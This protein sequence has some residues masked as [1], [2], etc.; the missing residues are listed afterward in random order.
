M[1]SFQGYSATKEQVG[2]LFTILSIMR[3]HGS[4]MEQR[5]IDQ[6]LGPFKPDVD[7][8]GNVTVRI[9]KAPVLWSCHVDTVH[10]FG[11]IAPLKLH[12]D[13]LI[14]LHPKARANCLGA[15]DGAGVWL[16]LQMIRAKR[17]GLYVF[18]RG[19][20]R[21]GIGSKWL[22][23]NKPDML[24][25]YS[26]A[27]AFD[28]KDI[29]SI[30][31]HQW[32]GRCCSEDFSQSLSKAIGLDM[33][34]DS[35]GSF[36][37]TASYTD[38][39]GECTNVSVGYKGQHGRAEEQNLPFLLSLLDRML[40]LDV[41]DLVYKR[42]PGEKEAKKSWA[43][44][45]AGSGDADSHYYHGGYHGG[46]RHRSP[47]PS[48]SLYGERYK[49]EKDKIWS[50]QEQGYVYP[51]SSGKMWDAKLQK[52]VFDPNM[53]WDA[54]AG[55]FK[56]K[57]A[58]AKGV[59]SYMDTNSRWKVGRKLDDETVVPETYLALVQDFPEQI[60]GILADK[61]YGMGYLHDQ[62]RKNGGKVRTQYLA[63]EEK[64]TASGIICG[65]CQRLLKFCACK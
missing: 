50:V 29:G 54:T 44:P 16:M 26:A 40:E 46:S 45:G 55:Y 63:K 14:K 11:G 43:W 62:I 5:F 21:G 15:D 51:E 36:T 42:K 2:E 22:A 53:V 9:G 33:K 27:I 37:D 4:T 57:E 17:P 25:D 19:E 48:T 12:D 38:L 39:I 20:E 60:A 64:T 1:S 52:W 3:P 8:C 34:S 65:E 24:K 49:Y 18:H 41:K 47:S 6:F 35:T 13:G 7:E 10:T 28:R 30:I 31:T 58:A 61:Q 23:K 59:R 32:G 56:R